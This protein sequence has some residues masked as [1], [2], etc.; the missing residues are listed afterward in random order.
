MSLNWPIWVS[1]ALVALYV[2]YQQWWLRRGVTHVSVHDIKAALDARRR[3]FLVDVREPVEYEAGHIPGAVNVPLG[4]LEQEAAGWERERE[5]LVIC[6]G[7]RRSVLACRRLLAM[8]F[9]RAM[10]V[11]GGMRRWPWGTV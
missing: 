4:R 1:L 8:G 5:I 11:D 9:T 6:G 3:F 2:G 7:G 10:N